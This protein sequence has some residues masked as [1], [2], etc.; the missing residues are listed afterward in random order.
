MSAS[1]AE[2]QDARNA[3]DNV[4][5]PVPTPEQAVD[6]PGATGE[7]GGDQDQVV[8]EVD[9]DYTRNYNEV[10]RGTFTIEIHLYR[11]D[12][13][14]D[15]YVSYRE[16]AD[17]AFKRLGLPAG[18]LAA[19]DTS[20]YK[21]IILEIDGCVEMQKL[22][23]TQTLQVRKGL[24]TKP[25]QSP[26]NSRLVNI[27]WAPMKMASA[28]IESVLSLFGEVTRPVEHVVIQDGGEDWQKAMSGVKTADRNC[29]MKIKINIPS[30]IV[31]RGVKMRIDYSGQPK[32]CS[33]CQKYWTACPGGGKVE[34]CKKA[35]TEEVDVKTAFKKLVNML[36]KKSKGAAGTEVISTVIPEVIPDPDMVRFSGFPEDFN[37]E[38]F[39]TWLDEMS[40]SFLEP[41]VFKGKKPGTFL[42][43]TVEVDGESY[44]LTAEE[45]AEMVTKLNGVAV[46]RRRVTVQM[47]SLSTPTK[48]KP[49]VVTLDDSGD[50]QP[51]SQLSLPAPE[52]GAAGGAPTTDGA[53]ATA[54]GSGAPPAAPA[55][56][57][58]PPLMDSEDE[59]IM[60]Q[61]VEEVDEEN[62][63]G[64]KAKGD[65]KL[66]FKTD[67]TK[68]GT[69]NVRVVGG[70]SKRG[71]GDTS[72]SSIDASPELSQK[73][74]SRSQSSKGKEK[75]TK[76]SKSTK[77]SSPGSQKPEKK[78]GRKNNI[79][80]F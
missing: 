71:E 15:F 11:E 42:I 77:Q 5:A 59:N 62:E 34:K 57:D 32:T 4:D 13:A 43:E 6:L 1:V 47:A 60:E 64:E 44:R 8:D 52:G 36:K 26:E 21:K 35:G 38:K 39:T 40:I 50:A 61:S 58:S 18:T 23:I 7:E 51:K 30:Q 22:N 2:T 68:T 63:G 19:V 17:L 80:D 25:L 45:A 29:K 75:N 31:I 33:R 67:I 20:P 48:R 73:T 79:R 28:D 12:R 46:E 55:S 69:K 37:I 76:S 66:K 16:V 14:N 74:Q 41:M 10:A 49:E 27:K 70:K 65:L 54:G 78:K 24:W 3:L 72:S 56:S 9:G 53:S